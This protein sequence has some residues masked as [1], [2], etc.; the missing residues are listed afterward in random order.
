MKKA[1]LLDGYS[2]IQEQLQKITTELKVLNAWTAQMSERKYRFG[3]GS[4][5]DLQSLRNKIEG[6]GDALTEQLVINAENIEKLL[7][8]LTPQPDVTKLTDSN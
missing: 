2:H 7:T 4:V 8:V 1:M 6:S 5:M 3:Q